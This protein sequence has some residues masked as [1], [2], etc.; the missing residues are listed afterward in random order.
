MAFNKSFIAGK[1]KSYVPQN[2]I[3]WVKGITMALKK[4]PE[5][6][7]EVFSSSKLQESPMEHDQWECDQPS[8]RRGTQVKVQVHHH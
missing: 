1:S 6:G 7:F 4:A 2:F 5:Q 8:Q 3:G